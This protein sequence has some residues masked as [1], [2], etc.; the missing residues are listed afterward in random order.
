M[1]HIDISAPFL[2]TGP[3][4]CDVIYDVIGDVIRDGV[5]DV[6][7]TSDVVLSTCKAFVV[8]APMAK[9]VK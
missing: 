9:L 7:I 8:S 2:T 3:G 5:C 6:M 4:L 1:I